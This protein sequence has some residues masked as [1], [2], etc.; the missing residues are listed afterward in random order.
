ML[1]VGRMNSDYGNLHPQD[2]PEGWNQSVLSKVVHFTRK[3][4]GLEFPS[5]GIPFIPMKLIPEG[6]KMRPGWEIRAEDEIKS[7]NYC[8]RGDILLPRITPSF[9]NGKQAIAI[10]IPAE[11]AYATTEVFSFRSSPKE[12]DNEFL[13]YYFLTPKVRADLT[14]KM[15]GTTGRQRIPKAVLENLRV[16]LPPL[17]E[18][19]AI[20]HV[21]STIQRAIEATDAVIAAARELK[22]SLLEHLV[23]HGPVSVLDAEVVQNKEAEFGPIPSHWQVLP[24][25]DIADVKGGKRLPKGHDYSIQPTEFP[26]I[27]VTDFSSWSVDM[28]D[29]RYLT[30]D[31]G[32][33]LSRYTISSD[34]VYISI[35]GTTGIVGIVPEELCGANLTEN[36]AKI[37][38]KDDEQVLPGFVVS[39]L[40]SIAGQA[41]IDKRTTKTSQPKLALSRIKQ[42]PVPLPPLNEQ[43]GIWDI[44][45]IVNRKLEVERRRLA[46][47]D[48]LFNTL[49]SN[50]MSGS[51][52]IRRGEE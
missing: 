19:R 24:I 46:S 7:G 14:G 43:Q 11:F 35:A 20:A 3:P 39:Y 45:M 42:I 23:T 51:L 36:A 21:L 26:Y 17:P 48:L 4:R 50:L 40:A 28:T 52:R 1:D 8:E 33:T 10:G 31:D 30:E 27:R 49:L 44:L 12:L 41:E 32:E 29:L 47:L 5:E 22:R 6:G 15:E 16:R 18:Q 34:D 2:L 37:M 13:F 9:E 38:M 25:E